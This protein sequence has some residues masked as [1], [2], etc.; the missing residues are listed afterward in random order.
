MVISTAFSAPRFLLFACDFYRVSSLVLRETL[1][2]RGMSTT[3][4]QGKK[5]EGATVASKINIRSPGY[6]DGGLPPTSP[7][8]HVLS[9]QR[10][11]GLDRSSPFYARTPPTPFPSPPASFFAQAAVACISAGP[12][13]AP[14]AMGCEPD[15]APIEVFSF[16]FFSSACSCALL[17]TISC[18]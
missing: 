4:L 10:V 16:F 8:F 12:P 18:W 15:M 3:A 5:A 6:V 17:P 7:F 14:R 11:H 2:N 1:L 9:H 13:A